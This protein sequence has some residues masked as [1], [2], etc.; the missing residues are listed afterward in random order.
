MFYMVNKMQLIEKKCPNCGANLSFEE[1]AKSCKCEY[2]NREFEIKRDSNEQFMLVM[3]KAQRGFL[4]YFF[5]SHIAISIFVFV[6]IIICFLLVVFGISNF[7]KE[8]DSKDFPTIN[9]ASKESYLTSLD[10]LDSGDFTWIDTTAIMKI[11]MNSSQ[12]GSFNR[13]G[14]IRR[15]NIYLLTKND[16]NLF[17]PIYKATYSNGSDTY[18][19]YTPFVYQ[20]VK[21]NA[22]GS[23]TQDVDLFSISAPTVY[24]NSEKTEYSLGYLDMDELYDEVIKPYEDEYKVKKK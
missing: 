19:V 2:C 17:I 12:L 18:T 21:L 4:K 20:N 5:V 24:F 7:F 1:N 9:K 23:I 10:D 15:E 11:E 3:E 8:S 14:S 13:Q 16:G 6:F 22:F